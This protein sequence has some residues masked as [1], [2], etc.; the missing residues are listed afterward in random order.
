MTVMQYIDE[1]VRKAELR[2]PLYT[3]EIYE[4]VKTK[5]P[6]TDKATFNMTLQRFEKRN[7]DFVRYQKGVY[8]KTVHTPFGVAGIDT[9]ELIKRTYLVNGDEV[10]GYESGPSYM[11]KIGLTTQMPNMTYI[12]TTRTRY[13]TEDKK[14]GIYL[15][16]PVIQINRDNYR[17]LQL[18][19]M[20]DNKMKVKIEADNYQ[21]ILRKQIGTFGL[22]FERL[23]GY[24]KYYNNN[25]V[26]AGLS[27]LARGVRAN[28]MPEAWADQTVGAILGY[29]EYL[30]WTVNF[31]T[32]KKSFKSKKVI[33]LP[34]DEWQVFKD[35]QEP[36]IDEET[37][38]AVQKI[39][40]GKRRLDSLGEP[41]ALSGML[42]CGDCGHRLYLRRQ[43]DPHQKD[44]FVCS[45]YRKK[46][47]YFCTSHFI[48]LADIEKILLRDLRQVTAFAREH[49]SEF[50]DLAKKRSLRETE[51]LRAENKASLDKAVRRIAE[52][53]GII[54][55]LYEDNVSGKI[56]DER[57]AKMTA[58]YETEQNGLQ[59]TAQRLKDEV[60]TVREEG[61]S[62]D[63]FMKLVNKYSDITELNAEIIRTFVEKIVVYEAEKNDGVKTQKV[64]IVYNCVGTV[65]VPNTDNEPVKTDK[66]KIIEVA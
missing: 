55:K 19:D 11:N 20:L 14:D 21:D 24:A 1:F 3:N 53:D 51:K 9:T 18:L 33:L 66:T 26:Y 5:L 63:R 15:I 32:K 40:E 52:I 39:R 31:K 42:F 30:G 36:I 12:V 64:K 6:D 7:P 61:E 25:N 45:V 60:S 58:T 37:F 29:W 23:I 8:Y 4:Y 59:Q 50:L 13:T 46:R 54:Q 16:K 22:S 62:V 41:N 48:R 44:Y 34:S 47:K 49:E 28:E 57:F 27:E 35:T 38:W 43:R 65:S 2:V 56:S 17:Y 10:I